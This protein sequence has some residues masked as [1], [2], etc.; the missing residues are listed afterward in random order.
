MAPTNNRIKQGKFERL[1]E[2]TRKRAIKLN[3]DYYVIYPMELDQNMYDLKKEIK[4][5]KKDDVVSARDSAKTELSKEETEND[6]KLK[7]G[8]VNN[9]MVNGSSVLD[10]DW[11]LFKKASPEML[12]VKKSLAALNNVLDES[13]SG[14]VS[15]QGVF[16]S[17]KYLERV[18]T[19]YNEF[20]EA[21][22][23]YIDNR[24]PSSPPG[25]RRKSQVVDLLNKAKQSKSDLNAM[26]DAV[27][28]GA[29]NF[30][31][32]EAGT[33]ATINSR[34]M[35]N[36]I[37]AEEA[38]EDSVEWQNEGNSTD[39]YKMKLLGQDNNNY[40]LKENLP[41]INEDLGGFLTRRTKQLEVSRANAKL[42]VPDK[43]HPVE[44]RL[45]G[46]LDDA[47]YGFGIRFLNTLNNNIKKAAEIDKPALS[48]KY[49][50]YFA[51]NFD[52]IFHDFEM[53]NKAVDY[54]K[55]KGN[56]TI[57][58]QID[59]AKKNKEKL[60]AEALEMRKNVMIA[61]GTYDP[62]AKSSDVIQ[63][64][65][66]KEWLAKQ[67]NLDKKEDKVFLDLLNEMNDKQIE[68][69]FRVT[70]GKEVELFGQM[71][72]SEM[73]KSGEKAAVNNT[74]TSRIAER[75]G[76]DDV[77]TKSKTQLVKFKRRDNTVV[78]KLCTISEEAPG[79][80]LIPLLKKAETEGRKIVYSSEAI[81]NLM[82]LQAIDTLC[83]QKD[84]HGRN[85]KCQNEIDKETGN[86]VIKSIKAYDNDMSFDPISLK[87]AFDME[88]GE[89]KSFQFLPPT[90]MK[91]K[92]D[93]A[94]YKLVLGSYF[95]IDVLSPQKEVPVPEITAGGATID[96]S[97]IKGGGSGLAY[98]F[99]RVMEDSK[100]NIGNGT[101]LNLRFPNT[102]ENLQFKGKE[103][104]RE[105]FIQE[106]E[107]EDSIKK[108]KDKTE[109]EVLREY[110]CLKLG[111][112]TQK[113]KDIWFRS[114]DEVKKFEEEYKK[115]HKT[116]AP[117]LTRKLKTNLSN[118]EKAELTKTIDELDKLRENFNFEVLTN[119]E[120]Y[121]VPYVDAF[122]KSA[123]FLYNK[124]YG[125]TPENRIYTQSKDYK[126]LTNLMDKSGNL[127]IP[128]MLHFDRE[129]YDQ[130]KE[131]NKQFKDPNSLMI[132]QLKELG[133]SEEKIDA[134]RKRNQEILD[135]IKTA[136]EKAAEF[137]K[138]A[139]WKGV[140]ARFLLEK[141]DYKELGS[142][143]DFAVD[144]GQTYLAVDNK[145]YLTGLSFD[146]VKNGKI[147]KVNYTDLMSDSEKAAAQDYNTYIKED[148]KRWKYSEEEK[149]KA[150][151]SLDVTNTAAYTATSRMP[152]EYL[153][154][155]LIDQ[156]YAISHRTQFDHEVSARIQ[157]GIFISSVMAGYDK[158]K[159]PIKMDQIKDIVIKDS[160]EKKAF[161][162]AFHTEEGKIFGE[163][164]RKAINDLCKDKN[165][166]KLTMDK[167][168]NMNKAVFEK[169]MTKVFDLA[170]D[171]KKSVDEIAELSGK[172]NKLAEN[173]GAKIDSKKVLEN[174]MKFNQG[175]FSVQDAAKI[176]DGLNNKPKEVKKAGPVLN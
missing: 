137:Y 148:K 59:E 134:L 83:L 33:V 116:R 70:M 1:D 125:D 82:R 62:K 149:Q 161:K 55:D 124:T 139:G 152:R 132:S 34:N 172:M 144:P 169:A 106:A 143:S 36:H 67:M 75:F 50:K 91:I 175:V 151:N 173:F 81:R 96:L 150:K 128:S 84:R 35:I 14:Y 171:R 10:R 48:E 39:V 131:A 165:Y 154:S 69:M 80:E 97:S 13:I 5:K 30:E 135:D 176:Q 78:N 29:I 133:F 138:A 115:D 16:N 32:M 37:S 54:P 7:T 122:L 105:K 104:D 60:L 6:F 170:K 99:M 65:S 47:D 12:W 164:L 15:D 22:Q 159:K 100:T 74:A 119:A 153:R 147:V 87:K 127:I 76:F 45:K 49:S 3:D 26:I 168:E 101:Y 90:T 44:E 24:N 118:E 66:A 43:D 18:N 64:V 167:F 113:L 102:Y 23:N 160:P 156:V 58:E 25:K 130:L 103:A 121:S 146:M 145:N 89:P 92:K 56:L 123:S 117:Y 20:F 77:I 107:N 108:S 31:N 158:L 4:D 11:R 93:S 166:K 157:E 8:A 120:G 41:F 72:A 21:A 51:H 95:G 114:D 174:Y 40:Y 111:K 17:K 98:G 88:S 155:I 28:D 57:D 9:F 110:A 112:L 126:A 46:E 79:D 162:K 85:F 136:S 109:D 141:E 42:E 2:D 94:L 19:A 53:Y 27:K 142:L 61:E 52:Q 163:E 86:I 68:K 129:A 140:K 71:S 63:K 73:Q 38:V